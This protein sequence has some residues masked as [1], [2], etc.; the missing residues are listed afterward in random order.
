MFII[1]YIREHKNKGFMKKLDKAH[2]DIQ[3]AKVKDIKLDKKTL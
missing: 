2:I 1:V 3:E